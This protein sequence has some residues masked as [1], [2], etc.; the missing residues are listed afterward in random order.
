MQYFSG[1]TIRDCQP[2][3]PYASRQV[4]RKMVDKVSYKF[5]RDQLISLSVDIG[6][7]GKICS[8][9][10]RK[11]EDERQQLSRVEVS[12]NENYE[13]TIDVCALNDN[14]LSLSLF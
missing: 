11:I 7:K 1:V 12:M 8:L 14:G 10:E 9:L 6:D 2:S 3:F 5:V 13:T 4:V